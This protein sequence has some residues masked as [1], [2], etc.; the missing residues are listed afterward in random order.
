MLYPLKLWEPWALLEPYQYK[1][2]E[3]VRAGT[4]V[5]MCLH[6]CVHVRHGESIAALINCMSL[7][8]TRVALFLS[9]R[10]KGPVFYHQV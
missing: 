2:N 3:C 8:I 1:L 4:C 9:T 7:I 10:F 5:C 6:M